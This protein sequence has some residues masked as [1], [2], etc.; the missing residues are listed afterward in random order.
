MGC[1]QADIFP[2]SLCILQFGPATPLYT[3][4]HHCLIGLYGQRPLSI[5]QQHLK[6]TSNAAR[7][8]INNTL[9]T[10]RTD[11]VLFWNQAVLVYESVRA[12]YYR[13]LIIHTGIPRTGKLYHAFRLCL[14]FLHCVTSLVLLRHPA[15]V[16]QR[17]ACIS[18]LLA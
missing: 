5:Y 18:S 12:H 16:L 10:S 1:C 17:P 2:S 7:N 3:R 13:A 4:N 14:P 11:G 15:V 9:Q 6:C 8:F